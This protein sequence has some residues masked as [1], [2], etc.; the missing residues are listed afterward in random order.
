VRFANLIVSFFL[1]LGLPMGP[2][3]LITVAGRKSGL[4][5]TTPVALNRRDDGWL[6]VSVWGEVDWVKNLRAS[7]SAVITRRRHQIPVRVLEL[8]DGEAAVGLR[9]L[10]SSIGFIVRWVIGRQFDT[11]P[12][13][14]LDEWKEEALRHPVFWLT[15]TN[16]GES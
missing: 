4:P 8:A 12:T 2:Q 16:S 7:G 15:P 13:A 5:R 9:D 3:A 11:H 1:R 10:V 6:L 14:S